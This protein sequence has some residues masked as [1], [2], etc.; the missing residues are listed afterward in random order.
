[1]SNRFLDEIEKAN[2]IAK[3]AKKYSIV[4]LSFSIFSFAVSTLLL[5][6]SIFI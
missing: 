3:K 6:L 5:L 1:M 2:L 4:A